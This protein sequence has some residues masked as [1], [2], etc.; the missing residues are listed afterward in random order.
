[1][2]LPERRVTVPLLT[3]VFA[4]LCAS[5][6]AA[7]ADNPAHVGFFSL[8]A[9][10]PG[11]SSEAKVVCIPGQNKLE[12][13]LRWEL[14][15][16][17]AWGNWAAV[18]LNIE[19]NSVVQP[20]YLEFMEVEG[21]HVEQYCAQDRWLRPGESDYCLMSGETIYW[22]SPWKGWGFVKYLPNNPYDPKKPMSNLST[23]TY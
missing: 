19:N 7:R 22:T 6:A 3:M 8:P 13:T 16:A 15:R 17:T 14:C 4:L 2:R 18:L 9:L 12:V 21:S 5:P 11:V 23:F 10:P 1:M 20:V